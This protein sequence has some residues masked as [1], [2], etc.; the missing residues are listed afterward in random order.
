VE[1]KMN[2]VK[3]GRGGLGA[4]WVFILSAALWGCDAGDTPTMEPV[5]APLLATGTPGDCGLV[6]GIERDARNYFPQPERQG[7]QATLRDLRTACGNGA[8]P[9]VTEFA[10]SVLGSMESL[11]AA[12]RGGSASTGNA[13]ANGLLACTTSLCNPAALPGV[14][15]VPALG[16]SGLFAVRG[17]GESHPV[18]ARGPVGFTSGGAPNRAWW[19]IDVDGGW[20]DWK[21][22]TGAARTLFHGA[23]VATANRIGTLEKE[24]AGVQYELSRFP[25]P[26]PFADGRLFVSVCFD[27]EVSIPATSDAPGNPPVFPLL[28]REGVLLERTPLPCPQTS[29]AG[30][31]QASIAGAFG[32][33]VRQARSVLW[34]AASLELIGVRGLGGSALDFSRFAPVA[35]RTDG[36]LEFLDTPPAVVDAGASLGVIR[37]R[38]RAG[39]GTPIERVL[40]RLSIEN[41]QGIPAGAVLSGQTE[42]ETRE[43]AGLEG[44]ATFPDGGGAELSVGKAG[45]YI[46]CA[47]ASLDG[48]TFP[49]V[50]TERFH[51][52]N[53]N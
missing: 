31:L 27:A 46:L 15:L 42:A 41:N 29:G 8:Q 4:A 33:L 49:R 47:E 6:Q 20:G 40:V 37:V 53:A 1:D 19:R 30:V 3:T 16:A 13:L 32:D 21:D 34:P 51:V 43:E 23:P 39:A 38:A 26:G 48:F 18:L 14:N 28:Q 10:W 36:V 9:L 50:C 35:A 11:L 7:V 2:G 22:V 12:G 45:G 17:A 25:N 44:V 52:R 24:I 5:E